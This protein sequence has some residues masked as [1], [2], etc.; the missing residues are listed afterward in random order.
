MIRGV[1]VATLLPALAS[2]A[3]LEPA[4]LRAWERY[5]EATNTRME[6]RLRPDKSFLWM[7][8]A[9]E[10]LARIRKGEIIVSAVGPQN[11]S[12]VP[13][14]LIHDWVGAVFIPNASLKDTLAVLSDYARY[15]EI[16]Q[17]MVIRSKVVATSDAKDRFSLVLTNTSSFL[18]TALETDYE[19]CYVRIDDRRGYTVSRM[20]RIQEIEEVGTPGE[21]L[22]RE[23]EGT[24]SFGGYSVLRVTRNVTGASM[25]SSK[26]LD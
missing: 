7:D 10:R 26:R 13:S 25:S 14:G 18:K 4:T 3:S 8:E 16:F 2:A 20:T 24:A 19:S 15:K 22:L 1:L 17:P 21:R 12:K 6:Q 5:I 9:P 11:P 23:G